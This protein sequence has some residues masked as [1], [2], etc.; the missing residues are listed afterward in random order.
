MEDRFK[1]LKIILDSQLHKQQNLAT[2]STNTETDMVKLLKKSTLTNKEFKNYLDKT[3]LLGTKFVELK[4]IFVCQLALLVNYK[5]SLREFVES[6]IRLRNDWTTLKLHGKSLKEKMTVK[7]NY[8]LKHL[9][10]TRNWK[11]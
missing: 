3:R 6:S 4:K 1:K 7:E 2:N 10:N 9:N 11:L 8:L 5:D